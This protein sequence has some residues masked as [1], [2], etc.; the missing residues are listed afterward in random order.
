MN[1]SART[2]GLNDYL[3]GNADERE[4]LQRSSF[5]NLFFIP[6]GSIVENPAELIGNGK[7]KNLLSTFAPHFDWI[8][9]DSPPVVPISD[10][11]VIGRHAD[12][13]LMVVKTETTPLSLLERAKQEL[14]GLPL[15]GVVLNRGEKNAKYS[16]YYYSY[17]GAYGSNGK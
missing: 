15:L 11:S 2:P 4:I 14:K 12:G 5:E 7:L 6:G 8:L 13:V 10:G 9:L 3:A 17:A 16:S 1:A